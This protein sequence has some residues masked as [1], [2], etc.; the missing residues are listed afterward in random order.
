MEAFWMDAEAPQLASVSTASNKTDKEP[1]G[2]SFMDSMDSPKP[3]TDSHGTSLVYL[4]IHE[5]L[6]FM[7]N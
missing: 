2:Q 7:V 6:I 4:P 3:M 1:I 5:W